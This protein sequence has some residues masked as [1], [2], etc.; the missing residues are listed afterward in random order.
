MHPRENLSHQ[1]T[2]SNEPKIQFLI[3]L[4]GQ[5]RKINVWEELRL[6]NVSNKVISYRNTQIRR[7]ER[8]S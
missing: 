3:S 5:K 4:A 7:K 1:T 2:L 8:K 6:F